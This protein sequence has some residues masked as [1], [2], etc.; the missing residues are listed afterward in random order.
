MSQT[1]SKIDPDLRFEAFISYSRKD[2]PFV[3]T[4]YNAL[5]NSGRKTWIDH[6]DIQ[7]T[8][9]WMQAIKA[10]IEAS[11]NFIVVLSPHSLTSTVCQTE[12]AHAITNKK[13][14]VPVVVAEVDDE[15]VAKELS[16]PNWIYFRPTDNF[17]QSFSLLI[18]ALDTDLD[19]VHE[20]SRLQMRALEWERSGP[21]RD[22]SL[23]LHGQEL[24][25]ARQWLAKAVGKKPEPTSSHTSFIET[26]RRTAVR[27]NVFT[28]A[29]VL[30]S[31]LLIAFLIYVIRLRTTDVNQQTRIA[32]ARTLAN[33]SNLVWT[34][35]GNLLPRS[36]LFAVAAMRQ[37]RSLDADQALRQSLSLIPLRIASITHEA[38]VN[39]LAFS[40]DGKFLATASDNGAVQLWNAATGEK[41]WSQNPGASAD[42]LCFSRYGKYLAATNVD[43]LTVWDM[44]SRE[45]VLSF[46]HPE[47]ISSVDLSMSE[48]YVATGSYD[49]EVR[50]WDLTD[51][52][53]LWNKQFDKPVVAATFSP[54]GVYLA[55][56]TFDDLL[57]LDVVTGRTISTL[58]NDG[59]IPKF[60]FN[61]AGKEIVTVSA[62]KARLW[63]S[64]TGRQKF[65]VTHGNYIDAVAFSPDGAAFATG[66]ADGFI[67]IWDAGSG[68]EL[69][70]LNHKAQIKSLSFS[71]GSEYVSSVGADYTARV[72]NV[73][74]GLEVAR[75][76][77]SNEINAAVFSRSGDLF[78]TAC[79][80]N[81][82]RVW[83]EVSSFERAVRYRNPV[84]SVR[85]S[86]DGQWVAWKSAD[87]TARLQR[88]ADG[89]TP[90][91]RLYKGEVMDIQFDSAQGYFAVASRA[92]MENDRRSTVEVFSLVDGKEVATLNFEAVVH[93]LVFGQDGKTVA[94][95]DDDG[96]TTMWDISSKTKMWTNK[97]AGAV[98]A[99]AISPDGSTLATVGDMVSLR[100]TATGQVV[101]EF[102]PTEQ[103]AMAT[104]SHDGTFMVLGGG[105]G[106]VYLFTVSSRQTRKLRSSA[107]FVVGVAVTADDKY[108]ASGDFSGAATLIDVSTGKEVASVTLSDGIMSMAISPDGRYV[109]GGGDSIA[110]V[111]DFRTGQEITRI[112]HGMEVKCVAFS[113]DGKFLATGGADNTSRLSLLQTDDLIS[114][115]CLRLTTKILPKEWEDYTKEP[116]GFETCTIAH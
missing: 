43:L 44:N 1:P 17:D 71:T 75:M 69:K 50:V 76:S 13:R 74:N 41:A 59:G 35:Q 87:R 5:V 81:V 11:D 28:A 67:R 103:I 58:I 2:Q 10:N 64:T 99:I 32:N 4:L 86:N 82:A 90:W 55:T 72:W 30:G 116:I 21:K 14:I 31:L 105:E 80:D 65:E 53:L 100:S 108:V 101:H 84:E 8:E 83:E 22:K 42:H 46:K 34:Q 77:H 95:Y 47:R 51:G 36:A 78:A 93:Y 40:P 85:F 89:T 45:P 66:A 73:E 52:R 25:N 23:L 7:P 62:G 60:A 106:G 9:P 63:E 109:T 110:R 70:S 98:T 18:K 37:H 61:P 33:Q 38:K 79:S 104:F 107:G 111:F 49:K 57:V 39:D 94:T 15:K 27:R 91:T 54:D 16:D 29:T 56:A 19:Y 68:S 102:Q 96:A 24:R 6:K 88:T 114:A 12:L 3:E 97:T 48:R 112:N 115:G 92:S 20:H 113:P 26:S